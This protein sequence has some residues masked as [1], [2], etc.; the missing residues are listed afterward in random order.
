MLPFDSIVLCNGHNIVFGSSGTPESGACLEHETEFVNLMNQFGD[1][2][3]SPSIKVTGSL[4]AKRYCT[5]ISG[6]IHTFLHHQYGIDLSLPNIRVVLKEGE[7]LYRIADSGEFHLLQ[8]SQSHEQRREIYFRHLF[9]DNVCR[10]F[11]RVAR[12]T[13]IQESHIW[14]T[15]SYNLTYWKEVWIHQAQSLSLRERIEEDYRF[16]MEDAN[17]LWFREKT[18]NPL[19]HSFHQVKIPFY[20]DRHILLREKCCLNYCLPGG[21]R[22]CY[23]CPL[24]TDER[25]IEKYLA[26]HETE[27]VSLL[28]GK[29]SSR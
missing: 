12:Y 29:K 15:L 27:N 11:E 3:K 21:D 6:A 17:H 28:S 23:T 26:A 18:V 24:I 25:R 20:N 14:E 4:F 13:G 5:L 10:V 9:S 8:Q 2:I 7:L 19:V 22:Y 16:M 1:F